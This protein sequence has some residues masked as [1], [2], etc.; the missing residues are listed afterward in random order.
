MVMSF[1]TIITYRHVAK[2]INLGNAA[3]ILGS[4][5]GF[6]KLLDEAQAKT[7]IHGQ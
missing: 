3:E 1:V 2:V 7:F 6:L 4:R 5:C